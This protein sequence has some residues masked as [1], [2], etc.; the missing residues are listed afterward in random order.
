MGVS[1]VAAC[2]TTSGSIL[3]VHKVLRCLSSDHEGTAKV[4]SQRKCSG[5]CVHV[6]GCVEC[7]R[8]ITKGTKVRQDVSVFFDASLGATNPHQ[9]NDNARAQLTATHTHHIEH[10]ARPTNGNDSITSGHQPAQNTVRA[11][12]DSR[13]CKRLVDDERLSLNAQLE[14]DCLST[15]ENN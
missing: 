2:H 13:S 6:N 3:H 1:R 12:D 10:Q 5:D 7:V 9:N 14:G 15:P 4:V 8:E 11:A